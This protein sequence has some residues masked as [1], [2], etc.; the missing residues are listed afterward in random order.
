MP[1]V[2]EKSREVYKDR[3]SFRFRLR[4][5]RSKYIVAMIDDVFKRKGRVSILDMGGSEDYWLILPDG[6]LQ[7]RNVLITLLNLYPQKTVDPI[8][9]ALTG[10]ACDTGVSDNSFDIAHSNSVIEHVGSDENMALFAAETKRVA[11]SYYVQTPNFWF[12]YEPHF[13]A[14]L[15][16]WLPLGVQA[17]L[18]Y[19]FQLDAEKPVPSIKDAHILLGDNRLL[20]RTKMER[21]F[22]DAEIRIERLF[23][24]QKSIM[25]FRHDSA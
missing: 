1:T 4:Q 13:H 16:H 17:R 24:L 10:S 2:G 19:R 3:N 14:P 23:G 11:P 18:A 9:T 15:I 7:S 12:P 20:T 8:F 5:A 6:Y 21:L 25:A 22:S